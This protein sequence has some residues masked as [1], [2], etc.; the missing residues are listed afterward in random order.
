[1]RTLLLVALLTLP[2]LA[3]S[4]QGDIYVNDVPD[5]AFLLVMNGVGFNGFS[6]PNTPLLEAY[7]GE[8]IQF[9]VVVPPTAEPHTFHLHGHP[10]FVPSR[11]AVVDTFLQRPGDVH[12]FQVM[13]GGVDSESGDWMYHC[14]FDQHM[15]AGMWGV[16]RV[17]DYGMQVAPVL[18]GFRVTLDRLG[19]PI[20]G[21]TFAAEVDGV[22]IPLHAARDAA[23]EYTLHAPTLPKTG[24]LVL[25]AHAP[26]GTSVARVGLGGAEVPMPSIRDVAPAEALLHAGH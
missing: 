3:A 14:H 15:S 18:G 4:A 8:L 19:A 17:Y 7:P 26:S 12:S 21:A 16:F 10:W 11:D 13:A 5:R 25:T 9:T 6:Y 24:V 20:D 1:M 22:A 2:F 23:G